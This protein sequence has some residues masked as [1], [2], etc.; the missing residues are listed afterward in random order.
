MKQLNG[1]N[2]DKYNQYD[3]PENEKTSTCP[4]CSHE[5][6]KKTDKCL[7]LYWDTGLGRCNHC[8]ELIQLHTY[9][10]KESTIH[11]EVP[12]F[13]YKALDN[14]VIKYFESRGISQRTLSHAKI[15]QS[16]EWMPQTKKEENT[17]N[18][19]YF[20]N[21]EIVNI[22][23][24]DGHKN[25]KLYKG[26][27]KIF[28][29]LDSIRLSKECIIVEGEV[30]ALSF[31][32]AECFNVVSIPNGFNLQGN[33]NIDYLDN[34]I[35]YFD[36]KEKIY[37]SFDNDEAGRKGK[38]EFVRRLG[39]DRCFIVDLK[40]CKDA[41]EYLVKYGSKEL[42]G[43]IKT[44][45]LTP[46]ENVVSISNFDKQLNDFWINGLSKGMCTGVTLFDEIF[47][48]ELEQY[49]IITG[50]PQSGKSEFLDYLLIKYSL[51]TGNK[52]G[53]C[54][55][56]N[57]PFHFHYDKLVQ[58]L[59]GR[60]PNANDIEKE[61]LKEVKQYV[62]DIFCHVHFEKRYY[63]EDVLAKFKELVKRKGV[64][65]FVIDPFNKVKL[66]ENISNIN[67]FTNEYHVQLDE[68]VKQTK[69]HLFLVAHPTKTVLAEGSRDS[70]VMPTAYDIKGGGEH[71]DMA[72]NV[73][74]INRI[75][76]QK[77][78]HIKTLKVKFRHLGTQ[79]K[80]V[81]LGYN[82][83]NGRYEE[84][85]YQPE[86]IDFQN[87]VDVKKLDY[88]NW[89]NPTAE[90]QPEMQP[91]KEFDKLEQEEIEELY[92]DKDNFPF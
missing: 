22:K 14:K 39:A 10:K 52:I 30:D 72:Y 50:V 26:A 62:D 71:F 16:K 64:R 49:T 57:E 47:T 63:L 56:E 6:K 45:E 66:K 67:D 65:L 36:N 13:E 21:D 90:K 84:L 82:T 43:T 34:Y 55:I 69:S 9:A 27:E 15:T 74:G 46:L 53:F 19:N 79:N 83:V 42:L 8:G 20:L 76:E 24:R 86:N 70:F 37:L 1:F 58:K 40:D 35:D 80:S 78:I 59:Y 3:L 41:N 11:Y 75:Y 33:I 68:F 7:S 18:F 5:R 17:I 92:L 61:D 87:V 77:I 31:I 81:F 23:Y 32:E 60:K 73:I 54:S 28:Y 38:E 4:K 48:P 91:N 2:I 88:S 44:A 25:F 85:E 89:L 51:N 12:K 29:N